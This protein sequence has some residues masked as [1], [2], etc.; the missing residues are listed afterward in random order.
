MY[1]ETIFATLLAQPRHGLTQNKKASPRG[2][3]FYR[4]STRRY[5]EKPAVCAVKI[6]H[7]A[8]TMQDRLISADIQKIL[9][10]Q[11]GLNESIGVT[12]LKFYKDSFTSKGFINTS[13]ERWSARK[14]S[15]RSQQ[16]PLTTQG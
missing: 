13:I 9:E 14:P 1:F 12:A 3:T 16:W 10:T 11:K 6:H 7:N 8:N 2:N 5:V 4:L 15:G